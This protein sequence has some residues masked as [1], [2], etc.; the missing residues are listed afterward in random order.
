MNY[1]KIRNLLALVVITMQFYHLDA[2]TLYEYKNFRFPEVK[3]KG[4]TGSAYLGGNDNSLRFISLSSL[5]NQFNYNIRGSYFMFEN[6]STKQKIDN[7]SLINYFDR[8][9]SDKNVLQPRTLDQQ[10]FVQA[11][12]SQIN[13]KYSKLD[14]EKYGFRQKFSEVNHILRISYSKLIEKND[15][16]DSNTNY[17]S[18]FASLPIKMGYGRIEPMTDVFLAQFLMDD[19]LAAGVISQKF[20]EDELFDLAQTMGKIKNVRVFDYRRANIYQLTELSRWMERNDIPQNIQSFTILN[21]NWTNASIFRRQHGK[22]ISFGVEP[23]AEYS[24][25]NDFDS[26]IYYGSGIEL[27]YYIAKPLSQYSQSDISI[28]LSYDFQA[29]DLKDLARIS[30]AYNYSYNPN[31]RTTYAISPKATVLLASLDDTYFSLN[32]PVS[33]S[34]FINY[35]SRIS[36]FI[37]VKYNYNKD[38]L[39]YRPIRLENTSYMINRYEFLGLDPFDNFNVLSGKQLQIYGNLSFNYAFF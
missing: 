21:D 25:I 1:F 12:K 15:N 27:N 17:T 34:Y 30:T 31:S 39:F 14:F 3:V 36:G 20:T 19:L 5:S 4:L 7:W 32:L 28:T 35:R 18:A 2:Q 23:W 11:S 13:R 10:F 33:V 26:N 37:G 29:G 6:T 16:F 9:W 22:R 38:K 24:K 8:S